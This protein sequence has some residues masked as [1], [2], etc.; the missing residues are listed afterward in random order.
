MV[1]LLLA[2]FVRKDEL[3]AVVTRVSLTVTFWNETAMRLPEPL[4]LFSCD[5]MPDEQ[6]ML[7]KTTPSIVQLVTAGL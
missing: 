4:P 1:R 6:V 7:R 5:S 2:S 3:F